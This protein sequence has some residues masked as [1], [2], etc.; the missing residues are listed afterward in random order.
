MRELVSTLRT[1][2]SPQNTY[3]ARQDTEHTLEEVHDWKV[4]ALDTVDLLVG[5][6]SDDQVVT[7]S[8]GLF[9]QANV[10]HVCTVDV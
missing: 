10:S 5:M 7:E 3:A 6:D 4:G 1:R 2:Q 8:L 9:E